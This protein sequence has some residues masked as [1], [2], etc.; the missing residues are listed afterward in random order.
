MFGRASDE[1]QNIRPPA[2]SAVSLFK[3]QVITNIIFYVRL[4]VFCIPTI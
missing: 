2:V 1:G 3:L 4:R